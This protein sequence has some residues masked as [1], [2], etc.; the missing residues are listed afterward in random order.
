MEEVS[1][2]LG[3]LEPTSFVRHYTTS[4]FQE[5]T[6]ASVRLFC[7][8]FKW[9]VYQHLFSCQAKSFAKLYKF[10]SLEN[11]SGSMKAK[12]QHDYVA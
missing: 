8:S 4:V 1:L 10:P 3:L 7:F 6:S 5:A 11:K 9:K 12:I 2:K